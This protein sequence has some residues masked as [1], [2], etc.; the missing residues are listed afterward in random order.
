MNHCPSRDELDRFLAEELA[1]GDRAAL[2]THV[3]QCTRCQEALG[4]LTTNLGSGRRGPARQVLLP[5]P[6]QDAQPTPVAGRDETGAFPVQRSPE[7]PCVLAP[8]TEPGSLGR[9]GDYEIL[10]I[11]GGGGM[12]VV[13]K[14]YD[15]LLKRTVAL[16]LLA[17]HLAGSAAARYRFLRE[18]QAAAAITHEN[19]VAI[20]AVQAG[21][22]AYLVLQFIVGTTLQQRLNQVG[23]LPVEEVRRIGMQLAAGLAAAHAQGLIHRD[24]KPANVLIE[25]GT[26]RVKLADFGLA[27]AFDDTS[28]SQPGSVLGTPLYMSPEQARGARI[29]QRSDLFSLGSVLYALCAGQAPFNAPQSMAVMKRICEEAPAPLRR[30]N[31]S[32]PAWLDSIIQ[33]LLAK[34]PA[35]RFQSAT[36]V[37]EALEKRQVVARSPRRGRRWWLIGVALLL[38][39]L[40]SVLVVRFLL[41]PRP[42]DCPAPVHR[43]DPPQPQLPTFKNRLGMEFVLVPKGAFWLNGS[44]GHP[45]SWDWEFDYA[46]Y[47]GKYEVTQEQWT[48]LMG[49][50]PSHFTRPNVPREISDAELKRFPVERVS[51]IDAQKFLRR[52]NEV[53]PEPGWVYCLPTAVEWEYACRGGPMPMKNP[54]EGAFDYYLDR[55]TNQLRPDQANIRETGLNRPCPVGSFAPNRLGLYDMHGN[56]YEWC[57]DNAEWL[58]RAAGQAGAHLETGA[59]RPEHDRILRGGCWEFDAG[60]ARA[61]SLRAFAPHERQPSLGLRVARVYVGFAGDR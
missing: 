48:S 30:V 33:K 11:V 25:E 23:P 60:R 61:V 20:H 29:D 49:H 46:F 37:V 13:L 22:P 14:G 7:L 40:L 16:K 24:I 3:E 47:L 54:A 21:P 1:A 51:W 50:N 39:G 28:L 43:I 8:S 36:E 15:P 32:V 45:S 4:Q 42:E 35:D 52:L 2:E 10:G 12:S 26:G 57:H 34:D 31:V 18:A 55:P 27:R 17:A 19:V 38:L 44:A 6:D 53:A 59:R 58:E 5:L 41:P 9:L 56:V